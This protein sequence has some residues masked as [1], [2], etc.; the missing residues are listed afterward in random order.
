[1]DVLPEEV[2]GVDVHQEKLVITTLCGAA[3][4]EPAMTQFE[5][6]TFTQDVADAAD[7][8]LALGLRHVA[9]ESTGI[10]WKPVFN[11]WHKVGIASTLCDG[12][13]RSG[14]YLHLKTVSSH[15]KEGKWYD[16]SP[17]ISPGQFFGKTSIDFAKTGKCC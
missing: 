7:R 9:I 13:L 14:V 4:K 8:L 11:V 15:K 2:A 16:N 1:M 5:C 10:Y 6:L 12:T 17:V 3:E